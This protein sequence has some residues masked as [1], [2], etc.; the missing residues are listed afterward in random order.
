MTVTCKLLNKTFTTISPRKKVKT[1]LFCWNK[2]KMS[3]KHINIKKCT[4]YIFDDINIKEFDPN[5]IKIDEKSYKNIFIYYTGY[6]T[7]KKDV[8]L[9]NINP[10]Y[11]IFGKLNGYF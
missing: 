11:V 7:I 3:V 5:N 10:L 2:L 1:I 8:K 4:C 9:C 6:P